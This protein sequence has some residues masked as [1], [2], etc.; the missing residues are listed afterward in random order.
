MPNVKHF[1]SYLYW[2][3]THGHK[4]TTQ[5]LTDEDRCQT[6]YTPAE[7]SNYWAAHNC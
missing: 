6:D 4:N 5:W 2:H 3:E 7:R 1:Y